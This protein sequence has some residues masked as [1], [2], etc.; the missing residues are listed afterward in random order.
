MC[1]YYC[2]RA[3]LIKKAQRQLNIKEAIDL[4]LRA[5]ENF[6]YM[7]TVGWDIAHTTSGC[8]IIEGNTLWAP[9]KIQQLTGKGLITD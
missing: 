1:T 4:A 2:F 9:E 5:S 6:C 8:C 3:C 7:D